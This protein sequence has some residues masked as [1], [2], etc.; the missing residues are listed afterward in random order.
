MGWIRKHLGFIALIVAVLAF[1][2]CWFASPYWVCSSLVKAVEDKNVNELS[3]Y[4]DFPTLRVNIKAQLNNKIKVQLEEKEK[5]P[6]AILGAAFTAPLV[7]ALVDELVSPE[8]ISAVLDGE[9]SFSDLKSALRSPTSKVAKGNTKVESAQQ[10]GNQKK[11]ESRKLQ[12]KSGYGANF[13]E[14]NITL[15]RQGKPEA[16]VTVSMVRDGF[17]SWTVNNV[18]LPFKF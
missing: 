16:P 15:M 11:K 2:G 12:W 3:R 18:L 7:D 4:V 13:D 8:G 9:S 17:F 6:L 14:F 5:K 10:E 1:V